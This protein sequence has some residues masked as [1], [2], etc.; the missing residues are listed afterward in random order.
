MFQILNNFILDAV[1]DIVNTVFD[2]YTMIVKEMFR[3][4]FFVEEFP[5][6]PADGVL[7]SASITN[8]VS[9]L[10]GFMLGLLVLKL[11]WKGFNVYILNRNGDA[12]TP[13]TDMAIGAVKGLAVAIAFPILYGF[14]VQILGELVV[15]VIAV[16]QDDVNAATNIVS[17]YLS[18]AN[19]GTNSI[20][21]LVCL[22]C[23]LL[24]FF[25]LLKRSVELL[26]LR[27][28]V[29]I[30]VIGF[31]D[32]DDGVWKTY[33]QL[34]FRQAATSL[35]QN[36]CLLLAMA[37]LMKSRG[38]PLTVPVALAVEI[39]ALSTP[40]LLA[41]ITVSGQGGHAGALTMVSQAARLLLTKGA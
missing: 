35:I 4:S 29:P 39:A 31:V 3:C 8:A 13:P 6:L 17:I 11:L 1:N 27:L 12:D 25:S 20:V 41:Q 18:N 14:L 5:G 10:Y 34:L 15:Q 19:V 30:A 26:I 16:M 9:L 28:G 33:M 32:S 40:K 38:N 7:T 2:G 37:M 21:I 23:F 36:F 22:I 24:L